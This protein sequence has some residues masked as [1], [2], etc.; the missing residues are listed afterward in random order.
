M[1]EDQYRVWRIHIVSPQAYS[2]GM[3]FNEYHLE[4]GVNLFLYDPE[5][6]NV[7]GS[8]TSGNNKPSQI[9]PVGHIKGDELIIELQVPTSLTDYGSLSIES[10]SHAFLD[11]NNLAGTD[12]CG[13]GEFGCSQGCEIDINCADG[14]D[15]QLTKKSVVRV[16]TISQYCTGVLVNNTAYDETPYVLTAEHCINKQVI[17]DRSVFLFNYESPS[18]D[19]EDGAI[20]MS[21]SGSDS[22][23]TGKELDF[24]LVKLSIAPPDSFDVYYAG[25][26]RSDF[27]T[28][29]TSTI[30]HPWGDVKKISHDFEIPSIPSQPGDVPYS[31]LDDYHY[32]AYWWIRG[33]DI[34]STE[35]GS[36]GSPLFNSGQKVIGLLSG[37]IAR[38]GDSIGYDAEVNKIIYNQAFNYDDYYTRMRYAWD[39]NG[40]EGPSLKPFLD[41]VNSGAINIG[42]YH[43]TS[44]NP[45]R[46]I[47][48]PRFS[49]YPNPVSENLYISF[50]GVSEFVWTLEIYDISGQ[51]RMTKRLDK[52]GAKSLN[53]TH[54][55]AGIYLMRFITDG[56]QEI[57]KFIKNP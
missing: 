43:P 27:Q 38:C 28:S 42:G 57:H 39:F 1:E 3:V 33:W 26:D 20:S 16:Y 12:Q 40:E 48:S 17:A 8:F 10:V 11:I 37:G 44:I 21:I 46:M 47:T 9:L 35:G 7:K 30:H 15:W 23:T 6:K 54:L 49:I 18:C 53:T 24:S 32:F 22:I 2:L 45:K 51:L 31:D 55:E 34:G 52:I 5:M 19:G 14:N 13:P 29:G 56:E 41:P 4:P 25:W 36:S 50:K